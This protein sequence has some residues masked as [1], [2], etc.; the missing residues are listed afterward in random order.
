VLVVSGLLIFLDVSLRFGSFCLQAYIPCAITAVFYENASSLK[1]G[2]ARVTAVTRRG[3]PVELSLK[4]YG[5]G[6]QVRATPNKAQFRWRL[7]TR[8][9]QGKFL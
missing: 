2:A 3:D 6:N 8:L 9:A 7:R 4:S 1:V 5:P